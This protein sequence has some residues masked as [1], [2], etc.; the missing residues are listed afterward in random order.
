MSAIP[1]I[2]VVGVVLLVAWMLWN[3]VMEKAAVARRHSLLSSRQTYHDQQ[4]WLHN[5][6]AGFLN[7]EEDIYRV[8]NELRSMR[9][10][11]S[12][13]IDRAL[14]FSAFGIGCMWL[15][16]GS[17]MRNQ[18]IPLGA[19]TEFTAGR[20]DCHPELAVRWQF[21]R[22]DHA[23]CSGPHRQRE[24]RP[25]SHSVHRI[26]SHSVEVLDTQF[27]RSSAMFVA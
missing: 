14:N 26:T 4:E 11:I 9:L 18:S 12:R 6:W 20:S 22:D 21:G 17:S 13:H 24:D 2:V 19:V 1:S 16:S 15:K 25:P 10:A 7:Y 5:R 23:V 8:C 3:F 27:L